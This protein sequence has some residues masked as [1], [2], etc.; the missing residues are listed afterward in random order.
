MKTRHRTETRVTAFL[1]TL[2]LVRTALAQAPPE[3][4]GLTALPK[5]TSEAVALVNS[6]F[7]QEWQ[8]WVP[9]K[10][11][12][13]SIVTQAGAV[14]SGKACLRF[15]C[16]RQTPY[17]PSVRQLLP[18]AGP[19][20]YRLRFWLK[21]QEVGS[22]AQQGGVRVSIEYLLKN[23][24]RAWPSTQV[25]RGTR[26]WKQEEL[27]AH[28][29]PELKPGSVAISIHRYGAPSGGEAF[30][31]DVSL[32]RVVPP[33]V[34]A[35]LLYPNYRGF[36]PTDGPQKIRLWVRVNQPRP[37][38]ALALLSGAAKADVSFLRFLDEDL[39]EQVVEVDTRHW[40]L[41]RY[42]VTAGLA[43][44][45]DLL[46]HGP[47]TPTVASAEER[48]D[49]Y[50]HPDYE[51]QE[52]SA[53][54]VRQFPVWFDH[55]QVLYLRGKPTFPIGLYNTTRQFY[56]RNEEFN[57]EEESGRLAKMSE[58]PISANINYWFWAP[59]TEVRRRYLGA[60]AGHGI[61]FLE[62][63]NHVYPPFQRTPCVAEL[64]PETASLKSLD[65][66]EL[67]DRYLAALGKTMRDMPGFLGWYVMDERGF[68]DVPRH[69]H[70]RLV[71]SK[72]DPVHPTF[73]VSNLPA[74]LAFWR[75]TVDVIGLDPYPLMNMKAGQPLT[76]VADWTRAAAEATHRSRPIWMVLQ[77]F[78]GWSTD[79]WPTEEELRTMSLMAIAEG[80]R[81]LFYWSYGA[82]ALLWVKDPKERE[83]YWQRL[84]KVT[85][86]LKAMEP[87]L[88]AADAPHLVKAVSDPRIRWLARAADDK[89]Y[90]FAYMPAE[91]FVA[92]P[93]RA[94]SVEVRFTLADG[95]TVTRKFRPDFADWFA[96]PA[97]PAKR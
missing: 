57:W 3:A 78:Q 37:K 62:T 79:R 9:A 50:W 92:D 43:G 6:G 17:V 36:L 84:V 7:E 76:V 14:H 61:G 74:E 94:E 71:L 70:Q 21:T 75:D 89:W 42:R 60:M 38:K 32:E 55:N 97:T 12:G 86:E 87:A 85:R 56:N 35:F 45:E 72:A 93:A 91:K 26:D 5:E 10:Q 28:I 81:G 88:V 64:L 19:G 44:I 90:V 69:F 63:V 53:E 13:F 47:K 80:A 40:E 22:K 77:F 2:G 52:V 68:G 23:G 54:Q 66:Q 46:T 30:F 16:G 82:R 73:G 51:V 11:E 24:Q 20:V 34:E 58:A 27:S 48:S 25:F 67:V 39:K 1:I 65:S 96:V 59:G 8:G 29:P 33:P 41:G 49:S 83:Q 18:Q 4:G 31:D 15:D 95:R